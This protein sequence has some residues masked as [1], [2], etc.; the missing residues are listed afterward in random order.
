MPLLDQGRMSLCFATVWTVTTH[1]SALDLSVLLDQ[2]PQHPDRQ[3]D[4]QHPVDHGVQP[5]GQLTQTG[6]SLSADQPL[7][8]IVQPRLPHPCWMQAADQTYTCACQLPVLD[9]TLA[10]A[11]YNNDLRS[12]SSATS[13][14]YNLLRFCVA[15]NCAMCAFT[16]RAI[17]GCLALS[18]M[19]CRAAQINNLLTTDYTMFSKA[20]QNAQVCRAASACS[21]PWCAC[22]EMSPTCSCM[23]A[24]MWMWKSV[25]FRTAVT[26]GTSLKSVQARF[27]PVC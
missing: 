11:V 16:R 15:S 20:W 25:L 3:G 26:K 22:K 24:R 17:C 23:S 10:C 14:S 19:T 4:Q 6:A 9:T 2:A 7:L 1:V 18:Q 13:S 27:T 21:A 8:G 5:L 12:A